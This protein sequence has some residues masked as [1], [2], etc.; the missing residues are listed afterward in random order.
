MP[1]LTFELSNKLCKLTAASFIMLL[2]LFTVRGV[3]SCRNTNAPLVR[4]GG[5]G[6]GRK[7]IRVTHHNIRFDAALRAFLNVC[8]R[9]MCQASGF[10]A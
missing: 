1:R 9:A 3:P 6:G 5:G 2:M 8:T 4:R 7:K 10:A